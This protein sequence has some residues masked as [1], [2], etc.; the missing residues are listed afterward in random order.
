MS[1]LRLAFRG[2]IYNWRLS[3]SL[4]LGT[5]I[6]SSILTGSLL[7]GDSV[8]KTL[9]NRANERIGKINSSLICGDRFVTTDL[10][11]SIQ[12]NDNKNIWSSSL[13][14]SGTLSTPD[15]TKRSNTINLNGVDSN[16]WKLFDSKNIGS[17]YLAINQT[18]AIQKELKV[19]DRI[20][21]KFEMPGQISKDAPLSGESDKI[22]TISGKITHIVSP[23][24]GGSFNLFAE[25][26]RPLNIFVPLSELQDKSGKLTKC[27]LVLSNEENDFE[28]RIN[29]HWKLND[30]ELRFRTTHK[31]FKELVSERVFI[32]SNIESVIR[33]EFTNSESIIS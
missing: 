23:S 24:N 18:L 15:K 11:A 2:F 26:E 30:I 29:T 5:F 4:V 32:S 10:V 12:D 28:E 13:R 21:V 16:F 19:G 27:N 22:G 33:S 17:E 1:I 20:I 14:F 3:I 8:K 9:S 6:A 25:Q 7:V 31:N